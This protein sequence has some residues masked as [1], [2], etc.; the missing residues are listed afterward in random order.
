MAVDF[1]PSPEAAAIARLTLRAE[2]RL[3]R[4]FLAAVRTVRDE[5][6]LSLIEA[7]LKRGDYRT[8]LAAIPWSTIGN[9]ALAADLLPPWRDAFEAAGQVT[10]VAAGEAMATAI[11]VPLG[12]EA[13]PRGPATAEQLPIIPPPAPPSVP[14]AGSPGAP[15]GPPRRFVFEVLNPRPLQFLERHGAALVTEISEPTRLALRE[16]LAHATRM[17][18]DHRTTAK[19][20][21]RHIGL[22]QRLAAANR[23]Y[24]RKL[25]E[26][27]KLTPAQIDRLVAKHAQRLL[28]YRGMVISRTEAK[29]ATS[30]GQLVAVR[31]MIDKKLIDPAVAMFVWETSAAENVCKICRP[32]HRQTRTVAAF[33]AGDWFIAGDGRRVDGPGATHP[34][35]VCSRSLQPRGILTGRLSDVVR[36]RVRRR[37]EGGIAA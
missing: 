7:A 28:L 25:E 26:A 29:Y 9:E 13:V 11:D 14:P 32:M 3:R 27:G 10:T 18:W 23:N 34:Q 1:T 17:G 5:T 35:C 15:G 24:R 22:T 19:D 8:A 6:L 20:L 30:A 36:A 33:L 16:T 37:L 4:A 31:Q 2:P 21:I 12:T